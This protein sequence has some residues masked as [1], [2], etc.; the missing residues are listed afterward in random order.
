MSN[1]KF[2]YPGEPTKIIELFKFEKVKQDPEVDEV[3]DSYELKLVGHNKHLMT[4][5]LS[6]CHP[7]EEEDDY[8]IFELVKGSSTIRLD[9][10]SHVDLQLLLNRLSIWF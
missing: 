2:R 8:S 9:I 10:K 1:K 3:F 7:K 5:E 4:I 6:V